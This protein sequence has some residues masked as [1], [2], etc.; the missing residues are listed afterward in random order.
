[1]ITPENMQ[2]ILDGS[3]RAKESAAAYPRERFAYAKIKRLLSGRV[4]VGIAGLRG[5]G[6]TVL[7]RQLASRTENS[8]YV[9]MDALQ[10]DV[11]LYEL[12]AQLRSAHGIRHL[13][14]DEIHA[15]PEWK[16][17]LKRAF[18]F[19]DVKIAFTSSSSIEIAESRHD[20][21][22]RVAIVGLPPFSFREYLLFRKGAELPVLAL[23]R[24]LSNCKEEYL[25]VQEYEPLFMEFCTGGA[26]PFTL[27]NPDPEAV[28]NI[29]DKIMQR[30]L[31]SV[32]KFDQE[33][34][35]N[36]RR[37]LLFIA[38]SGIEV[39]SYSSIAKNL[40]ITKYKAQRYVGMLSSAFVLS[41]IL[42]HGTN[43][44]REPKF[45]FTLPFRAHF[46]YGA[47]EGRLKGALR[48]EFFAHH[49]PGL[50][51]LK[52]A[53]GQKAPDYFVQHGKRRLV[54]EIGGA[55]K[56]ASQLKGMEGKYEKFILSSPASEK[57][58]PLVLFGFLY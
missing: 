26:L 12:A 1:M 21:S 25:K 8:A 10:A 48:E 3:R 57:G 46:S 36:V 2:G 13:F 4:F 31:P 9:S 45:I 49:V 41:A 11:R 51:Y 32:A 24:I 37:M 28:G 19:L 42:P 30:D 50:L 27:E 22:R 17:D 14:I 38:R 58:I 29:I 39:C 20:L 52:G 54:F 16:A 15:Y 18:D 56:G 40:G 53:K 33:D 35:A 7:L 5:S 47:D 34:A 43:L 55:G 44:T 23:E 6:K